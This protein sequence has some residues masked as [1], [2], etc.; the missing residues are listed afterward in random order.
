MSANPRFVL[1]HSPLVGPSTWRWVADSLEAVNSDWQYLPYEL[2]AG[3][4]FNDTVGPAF[5]GEVTLE[6]GLLAWQ[7]ALLE[8]GEEQG[9][10]VGK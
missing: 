6:D 10:T 1:V 5:V 2:Y 8:Y 7:D 3:T 9:F 4:I